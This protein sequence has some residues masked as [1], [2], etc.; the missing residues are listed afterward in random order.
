MLLFFGKFILLYLLCS[1]AFAFFKVMYYNIGKKFVTKTVDGTKL[2]W[3]LNVFVKNGTKMDSSD[4]FIMAV[5]AALFAI[6]L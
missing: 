6:Y 3:A 1:V 2:N 5:L 4:Y